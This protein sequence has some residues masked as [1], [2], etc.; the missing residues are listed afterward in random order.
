MPARIQSRVCARSR[1]GHPTEMPMATAPKSTWMAALVVLASSIDAGAQPEP[2][3]PLPPA[4]APAPAPTPASAPAP[5][6]T[7]APA[8]P[9]APPPPPGPPPVIVYVAPPEPPV[10]AP[11]FSLWAGG[12]AG[13]LAYSGGLYVNNQQT[14][15]IETTGNFVR[16]GLGLEL[17]VGGAPRQALHPLF[18]AGAWRGRG[19]GIQLRLLDDREHALSR[20][21]LSLPHGRCRYGRLRRATCPSGSASFRSPTPAAPGRPRASRSSA[22]ASGPRSA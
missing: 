16:P 12:R 3:P 13:L 19:P 5:A 8:P 21:G 4:S 2:L 22:S 7:S 20:S 18:R 6:P 14:G 10:H 11:H 9:D 15:S 17:D 1:T